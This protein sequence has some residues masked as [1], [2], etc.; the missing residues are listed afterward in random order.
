MLDGIWIVGYSLISLDDFPD[1]GHM[2]VGSIHVLCCW[3]VGVELICEYFEVLS[4]FVVF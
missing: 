2:H 1:C 3:I 4:K